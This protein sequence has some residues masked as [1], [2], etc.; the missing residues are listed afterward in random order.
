MLPLWCPTVALVRISP[1][2]VAKWQA[3]Y[4]R[5]ERVA[6]IADASRVHR[7]TVAS[8]IATTGRPG[9]RPAV[10]PQKVEAAMRGSGTVRSAAELLG[11]SV[12]QARYALWRAG[13]VNDPSARGPSL[14]WDTPRTRY[15]SV[16][17]VRER[18]AIRDARVRELAEQGF[19]PDEIAAVTGMDAEMVR[20]VGR[21]LRARRG[22]R[23]SRS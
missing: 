19:D 17:D 3:A 9:R 21:R 16:W 22:P 23:R 13:L 15:G 2:T 5:G 20:L 8:A 14:E 12:G 6:A 10:S 18:A 4:D 11:I 7:C 1:R